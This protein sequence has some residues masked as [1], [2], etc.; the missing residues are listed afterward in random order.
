M[1][2]VRLSCLPA[3][4]FRALST[5]QIPS[6]AQH[7]VFLPRAA[8]DDLAA[9][10]GRL[11]F[12]GEATSRSPATAHGAYASGLREAARLL[13]LL[14]AGDSGG[15]AAD[16]GAGAPAA[17]PAQAAPAPAVTAAPAGADNGAAR[18][19]TAAAPGPTPAA[20]AAAPLPAGVAP[21]GS[22]RLPVFFGPPPAPAAA[23][24]AAAV[25]G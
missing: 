12:A 17:A 6:L 7:A 11:L 1:R 3:A 15:A 2:V 22:G 14:R 5:S 24:P 16:G 23:G 10:A 21:A 19:P 18:P 25:S 13:P 9:P 8:A 4:Q 20:E